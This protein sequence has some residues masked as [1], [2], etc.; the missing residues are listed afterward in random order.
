[1]PPPALLL[2]ELVEEIL[3]R[4]PPDDP[5]RLLR[6][7]LA[8]KRWCRLVSGAGFR[9]R[10]RERYTVAP[11][12][13]ILRSASLRG[14]DTTITRFVP[15]SSFRPRRPDH[16]GWEAADSRH[17]RV[18]LHYVRRRSLAVWDPVTDQLRQ[19]PNLP[20]FPYA[21]RW[22]A[23]VLCT[24]AAGGSCDHLHCSG[25]PFLVVLVSI[26]Y[27]VMYAYVYSSEADAWSAPTVAPHTDLNFQDLKG[28]R[29]GL[30]RGALAGDTLY[31]AIQPQDYTRILKCELGTQELTVIRPPPMT[32]S[33]IVL[34]GTED[35][36][37]RAITMEGSKLYL[38]SME[39][40]R[41]GEVVWAQSEII[42]LKTLIP[43]GAV[44]V[45]YDVV[46]FADHSSVI[47]MGTEDHECFTADLK[48]GQVKKVGKV[49]ND[50]D[51]PFMR[52]C[53]P[54]L[55]VASTDET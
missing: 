49:S 48:S 42:E 31:F 40:V 28:G 52:F 50:D 41:S 23:V 26:A 17:G 54:A 38:W 9:R 39:V 15:T 13:G 55:R 43:V 8:C 25:G 19:L 29:R 12:L 5:A 11:V 3:L 21:F 20:R 37:L 6:A 35:G 27:R 32:N 44:L 18:L 10:F 24:A 16:R 34:V 1:M 7:A 36:G 53:T 45:S 14:L 4:I 2:D 30:A 33:H 22:N 46:S 51:I 47:Y